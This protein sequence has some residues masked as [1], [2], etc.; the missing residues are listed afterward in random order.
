MTAVD[1]LEKELGCYLPSS[2]KEVK[3]T[4]HKAKQ[5]E[6]YQTDN[7]VISFAEWLTGTKTIEL[8]EFYEE[9]ENEFYPKQKL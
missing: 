5:I 6:I 8:M 9:F 4:I 2:I 3:E 1:W 7:K